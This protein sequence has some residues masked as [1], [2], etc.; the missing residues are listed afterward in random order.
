M[1]LEELILEDQDLEELNLGGLSKPMGLGSQI[2]SNLK[3]LVP[4]S[5][6]KAK[7]QGEL[8]AGKVA[9]RYMTSYQ[10]WLG[11]QGTPATKENLIAWLQQQGFDT[12]SA[13]TI[14]NKTVKPQVKK[15][16]TL[17]PAVAKPQAST[18]ANVTPLRKPAVA[19]TTKAATTPQTT[20]PAVPRT[21]TR[22]V[23]LTYRQPINKS[24]TIGDIYGRYNPYAK[25]R[26]VNLPNMGQYKRGQTTS[27]GS[28]HEDTE[29]GNDIVSKVIMAAVRSSQAAKAPT[30]TNTTPT[31][32]SNV[33]PMPKRAPTSSKELTPGQEVVVNNN[34]Y[35]LGWIDSNGN[36]V[37]DEIAREITQTSQGGGLQ[38]AAES[39][40]EFY[41]QFLDLDL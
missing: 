27:L 32:P 13:E 21:A 5:N 4:F 29:I 9:N 16:P 19:P 12:S 20:T 30:A 36:P 18:T 7:G 3:T 38:K 1:R 15:E 28:L 40:E 10:Q 37:S 23:A 26:N 22:R 35:R 11:V 2:A 17:S 14:L 39:K 24:A 8:A 33:V 6:I 41:S 31:R 25:N 34:K